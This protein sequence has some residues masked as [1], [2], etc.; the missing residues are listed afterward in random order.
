MQRAPQRRIHPAGRSLIVRLR[1]VGAVAVAL[2]AGTLAVPQ[3][4]LADAAGPTDYRSEVISISPANDAVAVSIEGG[5]AF[6]RIVVT[7][8]HEVIV[9]GYDDEPYL[10]ISADGTVAENRRS[11]ATYYNAERFG[12]DDFPDIVDNSA[13]PEWAE[14]GTG[15]SWAWHD[16]RAHW[17][18][19]EPPI[20][21]DA[22]ESLP[23]QIVPLVVDGERVD[24]E[25]RTTLQPSPSP[26][27]AIFGVLIGLQLVL[28]GALAGPA[29]ATLSSLLLA[30]AATVVGVVQFR[31]LPSETGPLL[32]WWLLPTIAL[33]CTIVTILIYGRWAMLQSALALLAG[34]SAG[35][36]GVHPPRHADQLRATDRSA[37]LA[38]PDG[39]RCGPDGWRRAR[40]GHVAGA[41][42]PSAPAG[43]SLAASQRPSASSIASFRPSWSSGPRWRSVIKPSE[44]STT[45]TGIVLV[46]NSVTT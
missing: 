19:S 37:V 11:M 9:L 29:T 46:R 18:G 26:W 25:V 30:A 28:L 21:L 8:G 20:G 1:R 45:V 35:A 13:T 3:V 44:S 23:S 22:G 12:S 24:V 36:V 15:G 2:V 27:P 16:H 40:G 32:S 41:V 10:R 5:D 31:S 6:V 38:R 4:A 42:R 43:T 33:V 39:H 14:I 7:P 34:C 17:M